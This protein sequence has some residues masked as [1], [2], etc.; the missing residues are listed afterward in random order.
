MRV[1]TELKVRV[2]NYHTNYLYMY[3]SFYKFMCHLVAEET[4]TPTKEG[5]GGNAIDFLVKTLIFYLCLTFY[6]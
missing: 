5:P 3:Y 1:E 6:A 2:H 4:V